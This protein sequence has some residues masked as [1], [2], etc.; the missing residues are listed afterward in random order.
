MTPGTPLYALLR[1]A[2]I[3]D[4]S[5]AKTE[6]EIIRHVHLNP[7]P[8]LEVL[9]LL[10]GSVARLCAE[11]AAIKAGLQAEGWHGMD[12]VRDYFESVLLKEAG[13]NMEQFP[14]QIERILARG[15]KPQIHAGNLPLLQYDPDQY[16]NAETKRLAD[17]LGH[18]LA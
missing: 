8:D 7:A 1:H 15:G 6:G 4:V 13:L 18:S 11:W 14:A 17:G 2:L 9:L 3:L 16:H 10:C 5:I 12:M